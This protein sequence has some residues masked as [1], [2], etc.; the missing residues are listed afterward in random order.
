MK[1]KILLLGCMSMIAAMNAQVFTTNQSAVGME[2][3]LLFHA[4]TQFHV[5]QT[6]GEENKRIAN[7]KKQLRIACQKALPCEFPSILFVKQ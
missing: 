4:D 5:E 1:R 2:H 3:N 6:Q 7:L